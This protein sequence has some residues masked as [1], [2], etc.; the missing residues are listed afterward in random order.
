VQRRT[1]LQWNEDLTAAF[2]QKQR[3]VLRECV[4]HEICEK[5]P[6]GHIRPNGCGF[7][8]PGR[9]EERPLG[10]STVRDRVVQTARR[11]VMEPIFEREFAEHS[12]GFRPQKGCRDALRRVKELLDRGRACACPIK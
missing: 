5:E 9:P 12:Y 1:V 8:K 11:N 4:E 7:A 3:G 10:I 2:W 6:T